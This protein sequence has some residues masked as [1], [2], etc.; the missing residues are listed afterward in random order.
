VGIGAMDFRLIKGVFIHVWSIELQEVTRKGI[1]KSSSY[2]VLLCVPIEFPIS[3]YILDSIF[4]FRLLI[5]PGFLPLA[6]IENSSIRNPK[7]TGDLDWAIFDQV[8]D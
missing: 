1:F 6:S 5:L 3:I 8:L 7:S 2:F 4:L